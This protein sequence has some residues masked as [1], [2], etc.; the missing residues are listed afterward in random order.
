MTTTRHPHPTAVIVLRVIAVLGLIP[1]LF[2]LGISWWAFDSSQQ[3]L[4][5]AQQ[6]EATVVS[7]KETKGLHTPTVEF[8]D[9]EGQTRRADLSIQTRDQSYTIDETLPIVYSQEDPSVIRVDYFATHWGLA[10]MAFTAFFLFV[11][12]SLVMWIVLPAVMR[13]RANE[14]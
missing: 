4:R 9:S 8:T 14:R 11:V 12:F 13:K 3:F 6:V 2:A 10:L 7:Y 5:G 1:A